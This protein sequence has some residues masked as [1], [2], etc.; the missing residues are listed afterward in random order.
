MNGHDTI[1]IGLG[2]TGFSCVQHLCAERDS[3]ER[4]YALDTRASPPFADAV[5]TRFPEVEILSLG[6]FPRALRSAG[7][8][9]VSPGIPLDHC[10]VQQARAAGVVLTSDIEL[11]LDAAG[12]PVVGITGTNGKSTV[13]A[14]AGELLAA[15]GLLAPAGGNLGTPALD[16]LADGVDAYVLELSSF[17][18]ERLEAPG[19][20]V[21]AI[22]NVTADHQDR[23]PDLEAYAAAKRRI[24]A[25]AKCA[26]YNAD[27]P[28]TVPA[29]DF[30]GRTIALN[31]DPAW[32]IDDDLVI[33]GARV[34]VADVALKG[35]HNHFNALAAA[36]IAH[37]LN[38]A[39]PT[40]I[41]RALRRALAG[42]L[43]HRS[44]PVAEVDGVVFIDDSKAT[45][46]GAVVAALEG[47]GTGHRNIVLI[48]GGDAKGASFEA[49]RPA[50][51]R[52]VSHV[53]VIGRDAEAV[54]RGLAGCAPVLR[55]DGMRDAV[56]LAGRHAQQGQSVLLS[57]AC[58]SFDMYD[59]Y[60]ARGRDFAAAV[61][62]WS[63]QGSAGGKNI[64][65]ARGAGPSQEDAS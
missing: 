9:V 51:A 21:A 45:N 5:R 4:V 53:V 54:E 20:A 10:L 38:E 11:F 23:Y 16:L 58:A 60:E 34:P 65:E 39:P 17:Q 33:A 26:V 13:T 22:L 37:Q 49:L 19:L 28:L 2:A 14:L 36:A 56:R 44:A 57:P 52:H 27:D 7:R 1:V 29:A 41:R 18:L 50:V 43:P 55:A 42:G 40:T 35:R 64:S 31:Q 3:A 62:E 25:G 8:A 61:R 15:S 24:Y 30:E 46:V 12:A 63:V 59:G 48:A 6:D 47:F 32:R